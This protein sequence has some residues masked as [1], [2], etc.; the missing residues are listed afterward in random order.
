MGH[1]GSHNGT[2]PAFLQAMSP[3][4][5]VIAAGPPCEREGFTAWTHGHPREVTVRELETA[6]SLNRPTVH[7]QTFLGQR[8]PNTRSL[9]KAVYSTGWDGTVVLEARPDGWWEVA[10]TTGAQDC[11]N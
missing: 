3:K 5:A 8:R 4:M 9:S 6:V 7:V 2:T 1:H 10:E 11:P